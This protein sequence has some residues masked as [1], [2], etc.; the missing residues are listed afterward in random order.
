MFQPVRR[1]FKVRN[2]FFS[3]AFFSQASFNAVVRGRKRGMHKGVVFVG[4]VVSFLTCLAFMQPGS[5]SRA[6]HISMR[7]VDAENGWARVPF[8]KLYMNFIRRP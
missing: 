4:T 3:L 8:W 6:P 2:A 5:Q 1:R 7:A